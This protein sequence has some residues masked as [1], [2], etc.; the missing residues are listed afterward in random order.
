MD[1][2]KCVA[3]YSHSGRVVYQ[4]GA[5][6]TGTPELLAWLQRDAPGCF[7]PFEPEA[8]A[9]EAPVEDKA[10]EAPAQNKTVKSPRRSR[11]ARS[12]KE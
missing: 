6:V 5:I 7:E 12:K 2:L 10:V 11:R 3:T 8:K 1:K 9:V 4:P